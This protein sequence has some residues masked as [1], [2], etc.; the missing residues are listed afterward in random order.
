MEICGAIC[1]E[2][3]LNDVNGCIKK[4]AHNDIHI[5]INPDGKKYSWESDYNCPNDCDC[6]EK[7]DEC[8]VYKEIK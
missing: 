7:G 5:F 1:P 4:D 8:I 3:R 6:W 2:K